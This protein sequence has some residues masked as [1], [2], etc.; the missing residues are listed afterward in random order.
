M[1]TKKKIS[2][3]RTKYFKACYGT[4]E[5]EVFI[6]DSMDSAKLY[7][8]GPNARGRQLLELHEY[9]ELIDALL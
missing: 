6:S 3:S 4:G 5:E 8:A 2:D 1:K 9:T 7:A